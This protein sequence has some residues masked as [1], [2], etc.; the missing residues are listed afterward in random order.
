M[1]TS[2]FTWYLY[3]FC[4]FDLLKWRD[5]ASKCF[6]SIWVILSGIFNV[7]NLLFFGFSPNTRA[8]KTNMQLTSIT[9]FTKFRIPSIAI[10][11]MYWVGWIFFHCKF[12][13]SESSKWVLMVCSEQWWIEKKRGYVVITCS[14]VEAWTNSPSQYAE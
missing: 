6:Y 7:Y 2:G 1:F 9:T 3:R 11:E 13:C 5:C 8:R 10:I 12:S 4:L 14:S